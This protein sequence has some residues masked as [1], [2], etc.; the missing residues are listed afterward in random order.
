MFAM[1]CREEMDA[2]IDTGSEINVMSLTLARKLGLNICPG[3]GVVMMVQ[4]GAHSVVSGCTEPLSVQIGDLIAYT[5]FLLIEQGNNDII[6]RQS[7]QFV[8]KYGH[9]TT[10]DGKVIC[11]IF[12][13][14]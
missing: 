1:I 11:E 5:L 4:T 6:L 12:N 2:L 3:P 10:P 8:M 14:D 9:S 13:N 7:W